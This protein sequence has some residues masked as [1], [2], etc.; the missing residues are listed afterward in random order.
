[1]SLKSLTSR[2]RVDHTRPNEINTGGAR[3][4]SP[5][6][7]GS[8][9]CTINPDSEFE[10]QEF[11]AYNQQQTASIYFNYDPETQVNDLLTHTHSRIK[12]S[13][14]TVTNSIWRVESQLSF[15]EQNRLW[16]VKATR[17]GATQ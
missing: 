5:E 13:W 7:L 3:V 1:M 8:K 6:D 15:Q 9:I 14:R 4:Q 2:H 10:G 11:E 17:H 16:R 12:G